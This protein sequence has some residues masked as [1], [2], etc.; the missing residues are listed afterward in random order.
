MS[1]PASSKEDAQKL[2]EEDEEQL[3]NGQLN[4]KRVIVASKQASSM[5]T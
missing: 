3:S 5:A 4:I 2:A 1:T